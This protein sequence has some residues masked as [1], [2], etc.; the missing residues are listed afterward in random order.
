MTYSRSGGRG[1]WLVCSRRGVLTDEK[2]FRRAD[3][4]ERVF[5]EA[6]GVGVDAGTAG[7]NETVLARLGEADAFVDIGCFDQVEAAGLIGA[8]RGRSRCCVNATSV[9]QTRREGV[10]RISS[11]ALLE[12]SKIWR[13]LPSVSAPPELDSTIGAGRVEPSMGA[14]SKRWME[15]WW[16]GSRRYIWRRRHAPASSVRRTRRPMD[17]QELAGLAPR[18]LY[19]TRASLAVA[20]WPGQGTVRMRTSRWEEN[21]SV[22]RFSE[23]Q[24][25][26]WKC[27]A[28][29]TR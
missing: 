13:E 28:P 8:G 20:G 11:K 18:N 10:L 7:E 14:S 15:E 23:A 6:G 2:G 21:F 3:W 1:R 4:A 27:G 16:R 29:E 9:L 25:S 19:W 24:S 26:A 12:R 22:I 17:E 5:P